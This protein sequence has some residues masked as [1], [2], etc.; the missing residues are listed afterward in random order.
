MGAEKESV[1]G[2]KDIAAEWYFPEWLG[3]NPFSPS[4]E[5]RDTV[6]KYGR[7]AALT[8]TITLK[9]LIKFHGHFCGGLVESACALR[10]A[11][12]ILF[13]DGVIDR[14]NLRIVSNNSA[15]GGD[16]AAYLTGARLRFA[17]HHIDNSLTESDFFVQKISPGKTIHVKLNPNIYP[18]EV[19][20]QMKKI[21]SGKFT[22]QDI[23]RFQELQWAYARR[24]INRPLKESFIAE[25]V[26]GYKWPEP[27]CTDLGKRRD[28]D[29]KNVP[30]K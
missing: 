17:S 9:D 24:L 15:C 30:L 4:F 13:P 29:Y 11:F 6:N 27:I 14:T 8:K 20:T 25:E 18:V 1:K 10:V 23:D 3:T 2:E 12:D 5:V 7:Y 22:P 28:N 16:V 19:K 26:Q 21:E